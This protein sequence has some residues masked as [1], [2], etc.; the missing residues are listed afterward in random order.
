MLCCLYTLW[1]LG[2][3]GAL[4]IPPRPTMATLLPFVT[5]ALYRGEYVVIPAQSIGAASWVGISS[6]I[7]NL[8]D[9]QRCITHTFLTT[10]GKVF[11]TSNVAGVT[12]LGG[13]PVHW[14]W[15]SVGV[16]LE[17]VSN[18]YYVLEMKM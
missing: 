17:C 18:L 12:T 1:S 5:F 6:G 16:N 15:S 2:K 3:D 4:D 13:A 14:P 8:F 7:L 9:S 10:H 11:V